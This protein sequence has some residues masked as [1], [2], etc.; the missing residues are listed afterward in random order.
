M[1]YHITITDNETGKTEFDLDAEAILASVQSGDDTHLSIH[2]N[3]DGF[4]FCATVM[5]LLDIVDKIKA[6]DPA[7]YK[8]SK[9]L[10]KKH[11]N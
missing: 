1:K 4:H 7:I 11:K 8:M 6:D 2:T 5:G 3:C 9:K 10:Y